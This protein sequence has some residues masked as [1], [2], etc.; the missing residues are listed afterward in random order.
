MNDNGVPNCRVFVGRTSGEGVG[1]FS[2]SSGTKGSS[3]KVLQLVRRRL[4]C[5]LFWALAFASSACAQENL[6]REMAFIEDKGGQLSFAEVLL[7]TPQ[8]YHGLLS[9]G[10]SSSSWWVRVTLAPSPGPL[11][12]VLSAWPQFLDEIALF[13]P[14]DPVAPPRK[15]GDKH[16]SEADKAEVFSHTFSLEPYHGGERQ[17][18]LRIRSESSV[19]L[20]LSALPL[21]S[22]D[23]S[24]RRAD[25]LNDLFIGFLICTILWAAVSATTQPDRLVWAF[26]VKQVFHLCYFIFLIGYGRILFAGV[27]RPEIINHLTNFFVVSVGVCATW[28]HY[29]LVDLHRGRR[30]ALTLLVMLL[31]WYPFEVVL[32]FT[33]HARVALHTRMLFNLWAPFIL[34]VASLG[35]PARIHLKRPYQCLPRSALVLFYCFM[36]GVLLLVLLPFLMPGVWVDYVRFSF[37]C[38]GLLTGM[39]VVTLLY[40][41][42]SKT[43]QLHARSGYKSIQLGRRLDAQRARNLEQ[44][45]FISILAHELKTPLSVVRLS[46]GSGA[47]SPDMAKFADQAVV[48]MS[49][50]I[51]RCVNALQLEAESPV[52]YYEPCDVLAECAGLLSRVGDAERVVVSSSVDLSGFE[53][54]IGLFKIIVGNLLDNALKYGRPRESVALGFDSVLQK[55]V[56]C[57]AVIVENT[58]GPAG[59]PDP[60][61]VFHKFYRSAGAHESVGAGLGLFLVQG[62]ARLL[63][64]GITY[65]RRGE[66][67]VF[68]VW[69]PWQAQ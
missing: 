16:L 10:Y 35:T 8:V 23:G 56:R 64:G 17:Y 15:A 3:W 68:S 18:W 60:A 1:L 7:R 37:C 28:F 51:E 62:V 24:G 65:N 61:E 47:A 67:A 53:T 48:D 14:L 11:P 50:L 13:D 29:L 39:A 66:R 12:V 2:R 4:E 30:W 45:H 54:D 34:L 44:Q 41:R 43:A 40:W 5:W 69:I 6:V 57:L 36:C 46:L 20:S 58:P 21:G 31:L 52:V 19:L 25:I 9:C 32:L 38:E 22:I 49:G 42:S 27:L 59:F 55:G 63:H 33:G 26:V